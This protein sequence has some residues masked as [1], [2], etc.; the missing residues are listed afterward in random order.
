MVVQDTRQ[1]L[2]RFA[3]ESAERAKAKIRQIFARRG[4]P[5]NALAQP[6]R[7]YLLQR[8][9]DAYSSLEEGEKSGAAELMDSCGMSPILAAKLDRR[10]GR[11]DNLEV[12]KA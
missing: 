11:V 7:F 12:W 4:E 10:I 3:A 5:A 8:V 9:Q 2:D 6:Y 1:G